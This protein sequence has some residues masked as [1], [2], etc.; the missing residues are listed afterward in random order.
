M[1]LKTGRKGKYLGGSFASRFK[2]GLAMKS[3]FGVVVAGEKLSDAAAAKAE[4]DNQ[5][6]SPKDEIPTDTDYSREEVG[7]FFQR[8][9]LAEEQ[10]AAKKAAEKAGDEG[11][12]EEEKAATAA[13]TGGDADPTKTKGGKDQTYTDD[14]DPE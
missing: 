1:S 2:T 9:K 13:A 10:E 14:F 12:S 5:S 3:P 7:A 8:K 6:Q 11:P 4:I